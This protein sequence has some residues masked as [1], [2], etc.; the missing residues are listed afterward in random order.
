MKCQGRGIWGLKGK[1]ERIK[2][3]AGALC[4]ANMK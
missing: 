3:D 2:T 1:S 4:V